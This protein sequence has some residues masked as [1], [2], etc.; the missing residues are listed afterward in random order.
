MFILIPTIIIFLCF[1]YLQINDNVSITTQV[2]LYIL[3]MITIFISLNLYRKVRKD[4]NL[5]DIN[6]ISIEIKRLNQKI[7]KSKD[8]KIIL[9]L[10]HK[11]K[12]LEDE[13][14]FKC[15]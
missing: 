14:D 6:S 2:V 1:S 4:I 5:Q 12:L 7:I 11:I 8:E 3:M 15:H 13:K 9:G 10:K